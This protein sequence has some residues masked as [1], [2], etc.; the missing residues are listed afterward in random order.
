VADQYPGGLAQRAAD[1]ESGAGRPA[2]ALALD[3]AEAAQRLEA[4]WDALP[5]EA[6]EHGRGRVTTGVWSVAQL[7]FFR[8]REVEVHHT[9]L[10]LGY[11]FSDWQD[12]Y[13]DL[14]LARAVSELPARLPEGTALLLDP[15]DATS[16]WRVPEH[17]PSPT[18]VA[19][20]RRRLL[21]W[22]MGRVHEPTFPDLA[23][24]QREH[25]RG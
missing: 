1:I 3:V 14:E 2:A 15:T 13:V 9:D 21:A 6:W 22:L 4:A 18:R 5:E 11:G 10:G 7:P 23:P 24:W 20:E 25:R 8:W 16:S 17:A 19:A 12:D